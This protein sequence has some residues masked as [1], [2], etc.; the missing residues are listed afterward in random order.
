MLRIRVLTPPVDIEE[1]Q[2]RAAGELMVGDAR[3]CFLLDLSHWTVAD[4]ER[5]WREALARL[6]QGAPSSALMTAYRGPGAVAHAMW[7]LWRNGEHVYVQEHLVLGAELDSPFDPSSP[8]AHIGERVRAGEHA[9]PIGEW[10]VEIVHL[11]AAA[12]RIRWPFRL[13]R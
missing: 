2:P 4:Y 1:G 6:A 5:Q 8:H 12:L 11:Y 3:L 7:A 9:L 10:R 13:M